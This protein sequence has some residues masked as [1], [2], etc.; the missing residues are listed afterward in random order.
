MP[1][2]VGFNRRWWEPAEAL[3][4]ALDA[5]PDDQA[6]VETTIVNDLGAWD[7]LAAPVD[8]LDDL[9]THHLDLL[10]FLLDREIASVCARRPGA[11]EIE[12]QINFQGGISARCRAAFGPRS[13]ESIAVAT[14]HRRFAVRAGS[15]RLRPAEGVGRRAI[16]VWDSAVR[17]LLRGRGSLTRSY[18]HQLRAFLACVRSGAPASPGPADGIAALHAIEAARR[19]L[20]QGAADV[21]VPPTPTT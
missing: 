5:V 7:A 6:S 14:G 3:R 12:L 18:E 8:P 13:G 21:P 2:M 9:A 10:R 19:S 20:E 17:R 11:Q 15:E 1:V 4:R 16:D